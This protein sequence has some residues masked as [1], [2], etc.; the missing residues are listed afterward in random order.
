MRSPVV[1]MLWENWRLTRVEAAWRLALGIVGGLSRT[2]PARRCRRDRCVLDPHSAARLLLF[3]HCEAQRRPVH[4]RVQA[5][6]SALSSLHTSSLDGHVRRRR[7]GVRRA[8]CVRRCTSHP[9]LSWDSLSASR[10]RCSPRPCASWPTTLLISASSIRPEAES[11][12]GLVASAITLPM[13][14]LLRDRLAPPLQVELLPR[15]ERTDGPGWSRVVRSHGRRSSAAA[16]RR[17]VGSLP[18]DD[19]IG[20][21]PG[22]VRRPVPVPVSHLVCDAGTGV[23]R[24]EVQ[25]IAGAGDRTWRSRS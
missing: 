19:G 12:S 17:C 24:T 8:H 1:A 13:I 5:W 18:A 6:L 14:P 20:G 7:H 25:R 2:G 9:W 11:S 23:V 15:R 16:A 21:I 10:S 3:L 4:G 22:L